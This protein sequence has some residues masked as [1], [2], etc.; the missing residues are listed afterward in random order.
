MKLKAFVG[1][2]A[3]GLLVVGCASP[4]GGSGD[5]YDYDTISGSDLTYQENGAVI[6]STDNSWP[7]TDIYPSMT[8]YEETEPGRMRFPEMPAMLH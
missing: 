5:T 7:A 3:A 8:R 1:I 2:A 6:D 4:R